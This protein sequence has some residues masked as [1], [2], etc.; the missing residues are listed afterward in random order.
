MAKI[1]LTPKKIYEQ[2]FKTSIRGYDKTEVDEFLDDVIKD[3]TVYIALVKELQEENAK[4]KAKA[5][6][7]PASRPAYASATSEPSHATTNIASASNYDILKRISRLEKEV[8][9]KQIVE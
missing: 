6:S 4:L 5:T 8:F 9:G 2:E 1:N 3:Y 7:A